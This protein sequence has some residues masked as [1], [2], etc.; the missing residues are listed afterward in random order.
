MS[1]S[2]PQKIVVQI[3]KA[4]LPT[5]GTHPFRPKLVV[6]QKGDAIIAKRTPTQGPKRGKWGYLDEHD[7]IWIKDPGHAGLP[8]HWDVQID[9]G[10]DY[11]RVDKDGNELP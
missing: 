10:N 1:S 2:L 3:N 7:R 4:R 11:L 6:N 9:D 8:D 5:T